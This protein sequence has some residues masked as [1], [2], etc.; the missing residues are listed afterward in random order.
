[1][2]LNLEISIDA[3]LDTVWA[4]FDN[5]DKLGR[6]RENFHSCTQLSGAPGKVGSVAELRF[7]EREKIVSLRETITERRD[8]HF[9]AGTYESEHGNT[10]IVSRFEKAGESTTRWTS[11]HNFTFTGLRRWLMPLFS[12]AIRKRMEGDMQRF[13]LMVESDEAGAPS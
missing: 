8:R 4:A 2:K 5:P 9:L 11:W 1:M 6:W 13:K 3:R 7:N 10:T 12:S